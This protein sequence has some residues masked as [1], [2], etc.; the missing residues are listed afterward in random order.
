MV[1]VRRKRDITARITGEGIERNDYLG[2]RRWVVERTVAWLNGWIRSKRRS[3]DID[4]EI[5]VIGRIFS[6]VRIDTRTTSALELLDVQHPHS[7]SPSSMPLITYLSPVKTRHSRPSLDGICDLG[8]V[9]GGVSLL[10]GVTDKWIFPRDRY[11]A[12]KAARV[13]D[14]Y[15]RIWDG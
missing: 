7:T 9:L 1:V 5:R 10:Q 3:I 13:L 15:T 2:R 12:L 4:M 14:Q 8:Y 6:V 11:L